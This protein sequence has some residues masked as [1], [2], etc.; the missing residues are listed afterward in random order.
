M[1]T[2]HLT[3]FITTHLNFPI[4][5]SLQTL[6]LKDSKKAS[7]SNSQKR[8][9]T[10]QILHYGNSRR[11]TRNARWSGNHPGAKDFLAGILSVQ[12]CRENSSV[13]HST[14]I[15][16]ESTIFLFTTQTRSP[17]PKHAPERSLS[18]TGFIMSS[19]I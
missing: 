6:I 13:I 5:E 2:L 17:S 11:R 18:T 10:K 16:G 9:E 1:L 15:A 7:V 14:Y 8:N 4:T 3:E 12:Q 19:L